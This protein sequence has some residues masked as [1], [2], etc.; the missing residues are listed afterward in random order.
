M[1]G[2][3]L[4]VRALVMTHISGKQPQRG[5]S[6]IGTLNIPKQLLALGLPPFLGRQHSGMDDTRNLARIMAQLA[7]EG[8][9]LQ[10]NTSINARR[11]WAW[12]GKSGQI[13][14]EYLTR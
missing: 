12:M 11:R 10:P 2:D 9:C 14:G 1:T 5:P 3:V 7:L 6:R 13:V 4:D 8:V